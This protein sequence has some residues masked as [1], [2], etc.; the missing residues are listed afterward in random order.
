[1]YILRELTAIANGEDGERNTTESIWPRHYYFHFIYFIHAA[2]NVLLKSSENCLSMAS[3][4]WTFDI[5]H[6]QIW[7]F[8]YYQY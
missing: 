8:S 4:L 5:Y 2:I 6:N 7:M 1:M 3:A